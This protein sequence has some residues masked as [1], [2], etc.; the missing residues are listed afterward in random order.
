[1]KKTVI[2]VDDEPIIRLDLRQMLEEL[3]YEV[4]AEAADGFDAVEFCRSKQPDIALLDLEMPIFDGMTAAETIVAERLAGCVVICTAFADEDFIARAGLA[5]VTGY[6]VKP[7]EQRLL[8]PTL[9]VAF[10]QGRRLAQ[11]RQAEADA[12]RKLQE[13][14]LIDRAKGQLARDRQISESEAYLEMQLTAMHKRTTL[15]A[16]AQAVLD[17]S[18]GY[19][20]VARAKALL[21][22]QRHI[23][24]A[25]AYRLIVQAA[26]Q[27]GIS[28]VDA[29]KRVLA[30][31]G[32]K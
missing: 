2:V 7:I 27:E 25:A 28:N 30:R 12:A 18:S 22:Q 8:R 1:M 10:A 26:K 17:Q 15:L 19:D 14:R 5:G 16:I 3:D 29:A 32:L 11:S 6:L 4:V 9:E 21:M 24:E 31:K 23:S 13:M 20:A